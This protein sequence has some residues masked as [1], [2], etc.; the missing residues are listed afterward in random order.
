[1][2]EGASIFRQPAFLLGKPHLPLARE[3]VGPAL[4]QSVGPAEIDHLGRPT[5]LVLGSEG[6][7]LRTNVLR[8]CSSLV[9][10]PRGAGGAATAATEDAELVDSLNVSVAGAILLFS[11]LTARGG[12]AARGADAQ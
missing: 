4:E 9:R 7:G 8:A 2:M 1:M 5:V 3:A 11:M 10:I 6:H 12:A